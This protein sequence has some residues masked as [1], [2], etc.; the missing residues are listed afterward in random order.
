MTWSVGC[1]TCVAFGQ[2]CVDGFEVSAAY[3]L[4][5][6]SRKA[7]SWLAEIVTRALGVLFHRLVLSRRLVNTQPEKHECWSG[8]G[9]TSEVLSTE[10][11]TENVEQL[12]SLRQMDPM[13]VARSL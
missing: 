13:A 6:L 9:H 2:D 11:S 8:G 12:Q 4:K 7:R 5:V 1:G 10:L 3:A